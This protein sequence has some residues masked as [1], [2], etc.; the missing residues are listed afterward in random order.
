[1]N[2]YACSED[3]NDVTDA[4]AVDSRTASIAGLAA[5]TVNEVSRHVNE[6]QKCRPVCP[7][8]A[9][10]AF[11]SCSTSIRRPLEPVVALILATSR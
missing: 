9:H 6:L 7:S 5:Q 10:G 1:M 11:K 2:L 8:P 4:H 3:D